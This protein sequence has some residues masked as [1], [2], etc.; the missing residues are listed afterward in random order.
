M[1]G[2]VA[3]A[4]LTAVGQEAWATRLV[5]GL[6]REAG[7]VEVVRRCDD[8]EDLLV[9]A[10]T[11]LAQAAVV[12]AYLEGLDR[13]V[14]ARLGS[15]GLAVVGVTPALDDSA[16]RRLR[17][18]GVELVHAAHEGGAALGEQVRR[19]VAAQAPDVPLAGFANPFA[20]L[21]VPV[22]EVADEER[23]PGS[24][25]VVAVWGPT[26]A[27]GRSTVATGLAGEV[28]LL[29]WPTL[30][31]D[32]DVYGGSLAP[33]LG[34]PDEASGLAAA[35]RAANRGELDV[36]GLAA[37]ASGAA[38]SL[39]VLSGLG[40]AR[41]WPELR[42]S[43]VEAV[44]GLAR[45]VAAVTV[46]DCGFALEQDEELSYDTLAPRRN[47]ATLAVLGEAD[48][49]VVVGS[50]DPVGVRRLVRG[51]AEL[52]EVLPGARTSVVVNRVRAA[53][54]PE[55]Q[56]RAALRRFAGVEQLTCLPLDVPAADA[57]LDAG[58]LLHQVAAGSPLRQAIQAYAAS[59]VT[60]PAARPAPAL[61]RL[62]HR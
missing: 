55:R 24:G 25:R 50:A 29:G 39:S 26:G 28:A 17:Q 57:A 32:A 53:G 2:L 34:L 8:V 40:D 18:L 49:V 9:T 23:S 27:P 58:R 59:L 11:G 46:V 7:D 16:Q 54:E 44:L 41:R 51:L 4:V 3:T 6:V 62:L 38:P 31:V 5:D 48:L 61:R 43:A 45:T 47:G 22:P 14:L 42:P 52:E 15:L 12:S 1:R 60:P 10:A 33:A 13:D 30:L 35:C 37:L 21:P 56:V 20:A 19:A 36:P